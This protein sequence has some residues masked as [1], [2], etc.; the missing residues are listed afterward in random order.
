MGNYWVISKGRTKLRI[1]VI[2]PYYIK[3]LT[4]KFALK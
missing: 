1:S 2:I 4:I 3:Y